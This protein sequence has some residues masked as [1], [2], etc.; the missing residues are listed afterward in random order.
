MRPF[1][2]ICAVFGILGGLQAYMSLR[3][4]PMVAPDYRPVV[5]GGEFS[6]DLTLTFAAGPDPFALDVNDA[7]SVLL[8]FQGEDVLRIV[9]MVAP[10]EPILVEQIEGIVAGRNEFFV[11]VSPQDL[12]A[13]VA[14]AVRIRISRDQMPIAD[15]T[16]WSPAGEPVEG[17][18]VI[19][20]PRRGNEATAAVSTPEVA[21]E[22]PP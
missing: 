2:A 14:R 21:S 19:D 8:Q 6:A 3:P 9:E 4:R 7:P 13:N 11:Q 20:V 10:G 22:V 16:L 1:W 5:V 15:Q 17:V 18:I 12:D